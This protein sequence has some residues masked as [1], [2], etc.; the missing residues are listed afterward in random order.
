MRRKLIL[1]VLA[2]G[3]VWLT[4]ARPVFAQERTRI[5]F[6]LDAS[7]SMQSH[8]KGGNKWEVACHSLNEIADSI[9]QIPHIEMGLRVLG[10]MFPQP[11]MNCHDSR[12]EVPIDS[13]NVAR[14]KK[15]LEEIHP[16]GITPLVYAIEKAPEDFAGVPAKNVLIVITDGE[17]AC[18]RDA[19]GVSLMLQK[20]NIILRPFIIGMSLDAESNQS[21]SC[22]GKLVNTN[23]ATEFSAALKDAVMDAISKTTLQINLNDQ[24]GKPTET[25]VN[26]SFYDTETGMVRYNLYHSLNPRGLPDT[27]NISPMFKYKLQVHTIPPVYADV[28]LRK[29]T[30]TVINI[31]APQG[32]LNFT[33][34]GTIS[35]VAAVERIKC[36]LHRAGQLETLNVQRI[37]TKTKYLTGTY[38]LEVTTLPRLTVKNVKIDQSKTT[39]VQIPAPGILTLN[40]GF[41]AYGA[42]FVVEDGKMKKIYDLRLKD[43][44][45]TLAL[46]PGKYRLVYRS[47][48]A[49]TIHTTVDKEFDI[50]SGGSLSLKL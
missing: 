38:D 8:W 3:L 17:D 31:S 47:K 24:N 5:L 6:V 42:I 41:E 26:M 20:N 44:Q 7:L 43:R 35:K 37:N 9:G 15:K 18:D 50:T 48:N 23:N 21:L 4:G 32:Y 16:K 10:H 30:H 28:V 12:L 33:L 14:I 19:C 36:L 29:N 39:D 45:E 1:Y 34:Q 2:T 46:Q 25:D 22:A 49:R 40:K 13:N 27:L 11:D